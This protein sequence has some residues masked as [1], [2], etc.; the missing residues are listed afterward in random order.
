MLTTH[1]DAPH[2]RSPTTG[3]LLA[4]SQ[5]TMKARWLIAAGVVVLAGGYFL[6]RGVKDDAAPAA[7]G[8]RSAKVEMGTRKAEAVPEKQRPKMVMTESGWK[9]MQ[10]PHEPKV[11][12]DPVSGAINREV[13]DAYP[14][15]QAAAEQE[16]IYRKRRLRLTLADAAQGC[17][18][19]P[20]AKDEIELEYT[21]VV[22]KEEIRADNVRV[23]TSSIKDP[24]VERCIVDAVRDLRS[25]GDK[26]PDMKEE[27]GL[28]ISLHDLWDRNRRDNQAKDDD[29]KK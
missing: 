11:W 12:V 29:P 8:A 21:L 10:P 15:P 4:V 2:H 13:T 20:D 24:K 23:K 25:L 27:Q 19:G 6:L 5:L 17:Y 7:A 16:L 26:I 1:G 3:V 28:V 14:D 18:A 9:P 22:Q